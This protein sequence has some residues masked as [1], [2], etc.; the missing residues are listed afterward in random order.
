MRMNPELIWL[1]IIGGIMVAGW[2][3]NLWKEYKAS[4]QREADARR[5]QGLER[6][7]SV[8]GSADGSESQETLEERLRRRRAELQQRAEE[9]T[10]SRS[11]GASASSGSQPSAASDSTQSPRR[12]PVNMST[13]ELRQ[14]E[15]DQEA[16]ARRA[17]ALRRRGQSEQSPRREPSS[18]RGSSST[19]SSRA[20]ASPSDQAGQSQGRASREESQDWASSKRSSRTS[21]TPARKPGE[22]APGRVAGMERSHTSQ[23]GGPGSSAGQ[24]TGSGK[25]PSSGSRAG[26]GP[27]SSAT[28]TA[29]AQAILRSPAGARGRQ[30]THASIAQVTSQAAGQVGWT[31]VS[32]R[33]SRDTR[34]SSAYAERKRKPHF[35]VRSLREAIVLREI[36][37]PPVSMRDPEEG[38]HAY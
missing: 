28:G 21:H 15:R 12:E 22:G 29:Q 1:L 27:S 31:P 36:V 4:Q 25:A 33:S 16:Y 34:A 37:S 9:R 7:H 19:G 26:A 35:K 8:G 13:D 30:T 6:D 20:P 10:R 32:G 18:R 24:P 11:G 5:R 3:S 23:R 14:R 17:E 2:L 38:P